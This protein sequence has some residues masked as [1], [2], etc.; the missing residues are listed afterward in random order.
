MRR[1]GKRLRLIWNLLRVYQ[2]LGLLLER[3]N[4]LE[5]I[6]DNS[7]I[8]IFKEIDKLSS[9]SFSIVCTVR[10]L[11]KQKTLFKILIMF[12][13]ATVFFLLKI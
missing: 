13:I 11:Y 1:I 9:S 4:T 5:N 12:G 6:C 10:K 8:L 7:K 2:G 3:K